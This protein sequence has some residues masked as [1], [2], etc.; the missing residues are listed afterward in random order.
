MPKFDK[1]VKAKWTSENKQYAEIINFIKQKYDITGDKKD[2]ID[3]SELRNF[4]EKNKEVFSTISGHR[5]NEI[6]RDQLHLEEGRSAERRFWKGI[7]KKNRLL[8]EE[9]D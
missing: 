9:F 4:R 8:I 5:F 3:I 6:L 7:T 1:E 2:T